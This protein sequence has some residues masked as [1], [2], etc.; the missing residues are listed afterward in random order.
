MVYKYA[1]AASIILMISLTIFLNKGDNTIEF[2]DP[3]IVNNQIETGTDK[4][5]LT[6]E[7]GEELSLVK[8]GSFQTQNATSNGEEIIYNKATS[9]DIAYNY[10]TIPRGGQFEISLADG[11]RV[12]LNS[13]SQLKYP[14]AFT[15]GQTRQVELVY[16]EAYFDVSPSTN[17]KGSTFK[18]LTGI[19]EIEVLG[20][21]F[22]VKAYQ[23]EDQIYTTLA[24]GKV[25]VTNDTKNTIL[26]PSQQAIVGVDKLDVKT[27]DVY[28]ETAWRHGVFSFEHKPLKDIMKILSRWY[29]IDVTFENNNL[30]DIVFMGVLNKNQNVEDILTTIKNLK[31]INSFEIKGKN[32]ILK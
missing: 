6:L 24:E 19:Q 26:K 14:I 32:I 11:T 25:S 23:D 5:T 30:E 13:E 2:P 27:V 28:N 21:E 7:S 29:D 15:D 4:A 16:G 20:T 8:G 10:L 22:N 31:S 1:A 3:I 12:W 17:H 9:K 18:V